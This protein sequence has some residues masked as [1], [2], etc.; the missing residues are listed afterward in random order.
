MK[1]A[2]KHDLQTELENRKHNLAVID[3]VIE[4]EGSSA[5]PLLEV[6]DFLNQRV[7]TLEQAS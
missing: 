3:Q 7:R 1:R 6:R 4:S 2:M 5:A